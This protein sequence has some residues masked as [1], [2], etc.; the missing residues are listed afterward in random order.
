MK[1]WPLVALLCAVTGGIAPAAERP[2]RSRL[3]PDDLPEGVRLP[4]PPGCDS[5]SDQAKPRRS[6]VYDLGYGTT[7]QIGGRVTAAS[8]ARR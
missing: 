5:G 2:L 1:V 3:C 4:P 8:G 7:V 6:G